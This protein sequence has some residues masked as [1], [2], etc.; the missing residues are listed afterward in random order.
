MRKTRTLLVLASILTLVIATPVD[1]ARP[2]TI[3]STAPD[4]YIVVLKGMPVVAYDGGI[5]GIAATAPAGGQKINPH[6]AKVRKYVAYLDAQH[7]AL[8]ARAGASSDAKFY[9]YRYSLNGFAAVLTPAQAGKLSAMPEVLL[10]ERDQLHQKTTDNSPDFLGLTDPIGGLWEDLSL[11]GEDVIV[12]VID[13]GIWPEHPSFSDQADLADRPGESGKLTRVYDAPTGWF[14]TCQSGELWSQD[15]CNNKL[16]GAR[17]FLTGFGKH[18]IVFHDYKSARDADGHGTHTSSTAAGNAGVD[19]SIFGEDFGMVS[20]MAPRARVAMYK[21]CWNDAGCFGSDLAAA[22]DAAVADGVDVINYSIGSDT[23]SFTGSD[24]I[25]FLFAAQ[26]GVF[27]AASAGNAGPSAGTIG[28]PAAAPWLTTVGASTQDRTFEATLTLGNAATYDGASVTEATAG[29]FE[30]VDAA[31]AGSELCFVS[32]L[33]PT[34]V[35]GNIVLCKRGTNARVDKSLAV[36]VAGGV[37]M[38][39]YNAAATEALVTDNHWVPSVHISNADGLAVKAYIALPGTATA[40]ISQGTATAAQGSVMANF[41]SRGANLAAQDI[42]KPDVTAPGVNILAGNTPTPFLGRPGEL[43]QSISGTSMSSPHVV[44]IGALLKEAHPTWGLEEIKSALMTTGRQDVVKE[45]GVTDADL[46]D[47][48][49][50]HIVPNSATDPG[51][52][53]E[54]DNPAVPGN[55]NFRNYLAFL[56]GAAPGVVAPATC[57]ALVGL[58]HSTDGSDLNLA[59]IGVASL[60]G[61]ETVTR[62]VRGITAGTWHASYTGLAGYSVAFPADFAL[63]AGAYKTFDITFT[64]VSAPIGTWVFGEVTLTDG[65]SHTVQVPVALRAQTIDAPAH[66]EDT[67]AAA[68]TTTWNVTVGYT[69]T[70]EATGY[71]LV[72]DTVTGGLVVAQDPDQDPSTAT[73]TSGMFF[74]DFTLSGAQYLAGGTREA[75]TEPSSDLDI[76]LLY[77]PADGDPTTFSFNDLIAFS[78][79]GD[80]EEIVEVVHPADG[81]YRL[82]VHGWGT[83]DGASSFSL[84]EWVVDDTTAEAADFNANAGAGD[85]AA[86]ITGATVLITANYSGLS[87]TPTQYRGVV[88]YT[89]GVTT[90]ASTVLLINR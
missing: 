44:G 2:S 31:D 14:G 26:A 7:A 41:S 67:S 13:T 38:V 4:V 47:F 90:L 87:T 17:Y 8:L 21:A 79:D 77:K 83:P 15:D 6:S 74:K 43:F 89:D 53:F 20:G 56:C 72:A 9:D 12:G 71:G 24:D 19:A 10:V 51:L 57:T 42:I 11:T 61:T 46:F 36:Q 60:V 37:G 52:V 40:S 35:S 81:D 88:D 68:D 58:G 75:T 55:Q 66:V 5:A 39:L 84:H 16:I 50:G 34:V 1:A 33:D 70:L 62:T 80:S 23:P 86:V 3:E 54:A 76:Y 78:A 29:S 82:L 65:G 25:A 85:P 63:A 22:I 32:E 59:S 18:G 45:D 48:G 64:N 69:G 30:I 73:F 27:V 28:S 49:G